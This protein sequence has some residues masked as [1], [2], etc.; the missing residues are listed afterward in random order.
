MP[1]P[2]DSLQLEVSDI[3]LLE[4]SISRCHPQSQ[5]IFRSYNSALDIYLLGI[6]HD[7]LGRPDNFGVY[8]HDAFVTPGAT[9][10][11]IEERHMVMNWLRP[12]Y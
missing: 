12:V 9:K 3:R 7:L 8:L 11:Q 10:L 6:E 2:I 5:T 4:N 1:S